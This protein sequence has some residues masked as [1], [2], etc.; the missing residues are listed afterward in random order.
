MNKKNVESLAV[1]L[2]QLGFGE[3]VGARLAAYCCFE[4]ASFEISHR[5]EESEMSC[6]FQVHCT[7]GELGLYDALYFTATLRKPPPVP[8]GGERL[9]VEMQAIDWAGIFN[10]REGNKDLPDLMVQAEKAAV[11]LSSLKSIDDSGVIRFRHWAGTPLENMLPNASAIRTQHE[12]SQRF[13][14]MPDQPPISFPE[15]LRFMQSRWMERKIVADRKLLVKNKDK[16]GG[17][18]GKLLT[19][20]VRPNR[21]PGIHDK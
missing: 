20:R 14:L 21:K 7:K 3:S 13:Y 1:R 19:K 12:I 2:V 9:D 18:S 11:L 16:Q 17:A 5:I 15:A 10:A 4:P 8:P 6:L